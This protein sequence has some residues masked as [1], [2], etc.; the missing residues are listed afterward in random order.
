MQKQIDLKFFLPGSACA[1]A[2]ATKQGKNPPAPPPVPHSFSEGEPRKT[3]WFHGRDGP[4]SPPS[5]VLQR[6]ELRLSIGIGDLGGKCRFSSAG[7][8]LSTRRIDLRRSS[9]NQR[10]N[11]CGV[12]YRM[13]VVSRTIGSKLCI[14]AGYI[15]R[16]CALLSRGLFSHISCAFLLLPFAQLPVK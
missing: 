6:G 5:M 16:L 12:R 4:S 10:K 13:M 3:R 2:N 15:S 9:S 8:N 7:I 14:A 11:G 1:C